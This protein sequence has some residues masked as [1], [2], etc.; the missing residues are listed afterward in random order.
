MTDKRN[1]SVVNFAGAMLYIAQ[2]ALYADAERTGQSNPGTI[3][4][5]LASMAAGLGVEPEDMQ[6]II[7]AS[8][9]TRLRLEEVLAK[10]ERVVMQHGS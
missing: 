3:N 10:S 8:V 7:M 1:E 2:Q 9:K 5:R 4:A 6:A